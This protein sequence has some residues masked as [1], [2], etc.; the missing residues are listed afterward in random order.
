MVSI[1]HNQFN[2]VTSSVLS[3]S[4]AGRRSR[5]KILPEQY[6]ASSTVPASKHGLLILGELDPKA[7]FLNKFEELGLEDV[8]VKL[9]WYIKGDEWQPCVINVTDTHL[10]SWAIHLP[11]GASHSPISNIAPIE[12][13]GYQPSSAISST[14]ISFDEFKKILSLGVVVERTDID[15]G[16]HNLIDEIMHISASLVNGP[17][18]DDDPSRP[19]IV[20][21]EYVILRG[22]ETAATYYARP[23]VI[24]GLNDGPGKVL[25][26][27][28]DPKRAELDRPFSEIVKDLNLEDF[29]WTQA[30]VNLYGSTDLMTRFIA[31]QSIQKLTEEVA[32]Q[33]S[34]ELDG[35][36]F[37][38][39]LQPYI[40]SIVVS[41]N[42]PSYSNIQNL[43]LEEEQHENRV[44]ELHKRASAGLNNKFF[45]RIL[46]N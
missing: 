44:R 15:S 45:T 28:I 4:N 30:N 13:K 11:Y 42:G 39:D 17:A 25:F 35:S 3:L 43:K 1:E 10:G 27:H 37:E 19:F 38:V 22:K 14:V 7:E 24:L 29:N 5:S 31:D 40:R 26:T 33:N 46:I 34:I 18:I 8:Q 6:K 32:R 2:L 36:R 41:A 9:S 16:E 20:Q 21:G 12:T 23:C